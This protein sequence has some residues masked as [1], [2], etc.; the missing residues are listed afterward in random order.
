MFTVPT[1]TT[2]S[3]LST[4]TSLFTDPGLLAIIAA[5]I[6]I[7]LFFYVVKQVIGL[8]PKARGRRQ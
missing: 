8:F 7:P 4:V 5:V 6:A 2:A 3:V 1:S